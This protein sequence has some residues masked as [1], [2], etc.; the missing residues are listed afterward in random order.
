MLILLGT[1][2]GIDTALHLATVVQRGL[3]ESIP[4]L[5]F[6]AIYAALTVV[7]FL[8]WPYAVLASLVLCGIGF[9]GLSIMWKSITENQNPTL[10]RAI[11]WLDLAI[12]VIASAMLI[13]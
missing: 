1:L 7:V 6:T 10:D 8:N 11:W 2:L 4:N 9:V 3:R 12:L 5:V 13:Y